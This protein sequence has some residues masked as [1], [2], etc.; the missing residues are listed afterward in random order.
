MNEGLLQISDII[1]RAAMRSYPLDEDRFLPSG[2]NECC[3]HDHHSI[4]NHEGSLLGV[5]D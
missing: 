1:Q 4:V 5:L 3:T 2:S